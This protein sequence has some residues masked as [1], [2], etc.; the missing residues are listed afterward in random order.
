ALG[1]ALVACRPALPCLDPDAV[2][3]SGVG[4]P[5]CALFE[6]ELAMPAARVGAVDDDV[7]AV[8]LADRIPTTRHHGELDV[9][10][11]ARILDVHADRSR[12]ERC[13]RAFAGGRSLFRRGGDLRPP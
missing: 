7:A 4:N 2:R 1:F 9:A 5:P 11:A 3:R 12:G 6:P 13:P 10:R 8:A